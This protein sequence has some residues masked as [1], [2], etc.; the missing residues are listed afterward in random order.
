MENK[1]AKL[2]KQVAYVE[3]VLG[4]MSGILLGQAFPLIEAGYYRTS[5]SFNVLLMLIIIGGSIITGIFI[6]GFSEL[7]QLSHNQVIYTRETRD[8]AE[9]IE[10]CIWHN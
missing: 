6:L 2:I 5:E 10:S 9:R 8:A 4:T 7:I 3:M 1:M